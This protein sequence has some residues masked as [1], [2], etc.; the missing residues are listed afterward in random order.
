MIIF[1]VL[2]SCVWGSLVTTGELWASGKCYT[3]ACALPML[4][5]MGLVTRAYAR[6]RG[7]GAC[8]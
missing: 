8:R 7:L 6:K 3:A 5:V 1:H 2:K 4:L